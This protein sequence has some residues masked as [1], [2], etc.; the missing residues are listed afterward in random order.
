M[1]VWEFCLPLYLLQ[2]CSEIQLGSLEIVRSCQVLLLCFIRSS[3]WSRGNYFPLWRQDL[4]EYSDTQ[5]PASWGFSVWLRRPGNVPSSSCLLDT[6]SFTSFWM[7]LFSTSG[8]FSSHMFSPLIF[9]WCCLYLSVSICSLCKEFSFLV[10]CPY[11]FS[12]LGLTWC[13]LWECSGLGLSFSPCALG[14]KNSQGVKLG[15]LRAHLICLL[16]LWDY[17]RCYLIHRSWKPL[18]QLFYLFILFLPWEVCIVH[19]GSQIWSLFLHRDQK[20]SAIFFFF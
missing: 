17:Y 12:C 19:A 13:E 15:K 20:K 6:V 14:W 7:V 8:N 11:S 16:F 9:K 5:C 10:L 18:S 4:S 2:V 1:E 3:T